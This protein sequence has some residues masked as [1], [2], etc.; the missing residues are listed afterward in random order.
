MGA[1]KNHRQQ[2]ALT[3]TASDAEKL[4]FFHRVRLITTLPPAEIYVN[5]YMNEYP[6]IN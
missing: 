5:V 3:K 1:L 2:I 6:L 4:F